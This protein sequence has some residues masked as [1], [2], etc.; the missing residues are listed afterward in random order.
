MGFSLKYSV[1]NE[2]NLIDAIGV[3][4]P[5]GA[6]GEL[7]CFAACQLLS[8][9][10]LVIGDAPGPDGREGA[11]ALQ[12][13]ARKALPRG[14]EGVWIEAG[15]ATQI[16]AVGGDAVFVAIDESDLP[17]AVIDLRTRLTKRQRQQRSLYALSPAEL[18]PTTVKWEVVR[19][20]DASPARPR[21]PPTGRP[22]TGAFVT[23]P[24]GIFVADAKSCSGDVLQ[25]PLSGVVLEPRSPM[26][27]VRVD[28]ADGRR[29][30]VPFGLRHRLSLR[31]ASQS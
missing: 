19:A 5:T 16:C 2:K 30:I 1:S 31:S 9:L 8:H 20:T 3:D 15:T 23:I 6:D 25:A 10:A 12:D 27:D 18:R 22:T 17:S 14:Q 4:W 7:D 13:G 28:L 26:D 24:A 29:V 11:W 21:R